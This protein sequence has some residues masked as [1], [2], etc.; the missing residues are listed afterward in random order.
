MDEHS[1]LVT[2]AVFVAVAAIALLIQAGFLFGIYKS[3]KAMHDNTVRVLPKIESLVTTSQAAIEDG[4]VRFSEISVRTEAI[5]D[6]A[7]R[8]METVDHFL[9]DATETAR[10]QMATVDSFLTD[11]ASRGRN[12]LERAELFLDDTMGRAQQTVAMVH[13]SVITPVR[14][15]NSLA[16]GLR[17]A[18]Q[19]FVSRNQHSP[20]RATVDEEMFI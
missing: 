18:L 3:T 20:D 12:Q 9:T 11:A 17:A 6:T 2:M 14:Q 7:Q 5:L 19:Y 1:L 15:I 13:S 10:K 4:R 16:T 8:Q